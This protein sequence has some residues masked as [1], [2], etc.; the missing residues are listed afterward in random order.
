MKLLA[1]V[2][3]SSFL[4]FGC[5]SGTEVA[6]VGSATG[7]RMGDEHV[8]VHAALDCAVAE[9]MPRVDG[10][11]DADDS[12]ICVHALWIAADD[13][14]GT[15]PM[16]ASKVCAYIGSVR[17]MTFTLVSDGPVPSNAAKVSVYTDD[18]S[19]AMGTASKPV[20]IDSP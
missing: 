15:S 19:R 7:E 3:L 10:R 20:V 6:V 11:C 17:G 4:V 18:Q 9:G 14:S 13:V 16:A 5:E 8:R 1:L 12:T 2:I